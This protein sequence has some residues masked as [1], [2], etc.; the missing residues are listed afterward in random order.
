M[1]YKLL[2]TVEWDDARAAGHLA[3]SA[4]DRQD[5]FIHLSAADQVVETARRHF[6]GATGLTLLSV[7]EQRLGDVL[8]WEPSRGG[9]LFPHLYG[10]LPVTAVVAARVLPVDVPVADAVAALLD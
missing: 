5:G 4:V 6:A 9:H 3:G 1:I 2:P 10:P 8:R 7:D